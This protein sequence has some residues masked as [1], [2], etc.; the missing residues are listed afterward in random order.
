MSLRK[1]R[2]GRTA[3]QGVENASFRCFS[4]NGDRGRIEI[5]H[6]YGLCCRVLYC[7]PA[8][9]SLCRP[10]AAGTT[11][12]VPDSSTNHPSTNRIVI[13][14]FYHLRIRVGLGMG[15]SIR[16]SIWPRSDEFPPF[17][18]LWLVGQFLRISWQTSQGI[19][20]KLS[21]YIHFDIPK[22]RRKISQAMLY[23]RGFL[24]SGYLIRCSAAAHRLLIR[25]S[26]THL[27]MG[28]HGLINF[29]LS[30]R[31]SHAAF[32][33][34]SNCRAFADKSLIGLSL[35][36]MSQFITSLLWLDYTMV[37]LCWISSVSWPLL[38]SNWAQIR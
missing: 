28:F 9:H 1:R 30:C 29:W 26:V 18:G 32:N 5:D 20:V 11:Q 34:S 3:V 17:P 21:K 6:L 7:Y 16:P 19:D 23:S 31:R 36:S 10:Q 12:V 33:W 14:C 38:R 4:Q 13:N 8:Q 37:T 24:F 2:W 25:L 15:L 35:N 27:T 22:G